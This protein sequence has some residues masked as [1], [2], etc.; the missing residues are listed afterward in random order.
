MAACAKNP[1]EKCKLWSLAESEWRAG[2]RV[3]YFANW[4]KTL[5]KNKL[6]QLFS[7]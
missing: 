4:E 1:E 7:D 2:V 6:T 5:A 3:E